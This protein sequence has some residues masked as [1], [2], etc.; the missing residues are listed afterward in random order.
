VPA[1][2]A[3]LSRFQA[4]NTQVLGIS[5]DSIYSHAN[6]AASLGGISFPLLADFHPKGAVAESLGLYL[7]DKGI[8]DRATVILDASGVIQFVE[9][10]GPG[11]ERNIDELAARCEAVDKKYQGERR[12]WG[13]PSGLDTDVRLYVKSNCGFSRAVLLAHENLHLKQ[14]IPVENV[15]ENPYAMA[16]LK[17]L[18]GKG[19]APCLVSD[20]KAMY[21]SAD[22][23]K[24]LVT[25]TLPPL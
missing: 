25:A 13:E 1:V 18:G 19:Q 11:G 9:A 17:A 8:T 7:S 12:G 5:V 6:W 3:N 23:I 22:I 21:E 20:G 15:S 10:V 14:A 2:E 24:H 16:R 4:A